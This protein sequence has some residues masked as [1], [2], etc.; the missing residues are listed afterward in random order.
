MHVIIIKFTSKTTVRVPLDISFKDNVLDEVNSTEFLGTYIDN[1][2][3]QK[4][5]TEQ[6]SHNLNA[7]CFTIRHL[8]HTL[9][10]DT[11]RMVYF[12]Y[13]QPVLQYGIIF[14]EK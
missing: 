4:T 11:L 1:H 6:I 7:V 13:F 9:N 8:M 14:G 3:N 10:A 5:H 2:M 12:A